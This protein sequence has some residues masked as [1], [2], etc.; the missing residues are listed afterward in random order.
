[1]K[2]ASMVEL[3]VDSEVEDKLKVLCCLSAKLWNEVNYARR[4]SFF[5]KM[6]VDLKY[7]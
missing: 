1:M 7:T 5:E 4:R 6:G 2:R 3:V